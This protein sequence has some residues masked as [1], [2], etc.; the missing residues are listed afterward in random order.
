LLGG[1]LKYKLGTKEVPPFEKGIVKSTSR[2]T[3][4]TDPNYKSNHNPANIK[5]KIRLLRKLLVQKDQ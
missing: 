3:A 2:T 5:T 1:G 4:Y